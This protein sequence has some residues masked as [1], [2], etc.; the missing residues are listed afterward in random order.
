[1]Q[2]C[3]GSGTGEWSQWRIIQQK[4]KSKPACNSHNWIQMVNSDFQPAND[5]MSLYPGSFRKGTKA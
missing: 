1:M 2:E 4:K 3:S 5:G